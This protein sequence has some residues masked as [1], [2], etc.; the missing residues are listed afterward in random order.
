MD[1]T[2]P[3]ARTGGTDAPELEGVPQGEDDD[4]GVEVLPAGVRPVVAAVVR[5]LEPVC[6]GWITRAR[7]D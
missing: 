3:G 7:Q 2:M 6:G 1:Q 5:Q 4:D